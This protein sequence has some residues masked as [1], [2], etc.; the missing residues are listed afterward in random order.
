MTT[1]ENLQTTES[2]GLNAADRRANRK[3]RILG[4]LAGRYRAVPVLVAILT[5]WIFFTSQNPLFLSPRNLTNLSVQ[6]VVTALLALGLVLILVVKEID[7][8]IAALSAV[9]AAVMSKLMVELGLPVVVAI[10]AAILTGM[11]VGLIQGIII[12]RFRAAAFIV[13][14]GTSLAL[15]GVLLYLLPQSGSIALA[16][17][18]IQAIANSFLTPIVGYLLAL[19]GVAATLLLT[20][21]S[22]SHKIKQ[23]MTSRFLT[24]VLLPSAGVLVVTLI[25]VFVLNLD[26]G[27]PTP[28]AILVVLLGVMAYV[29]TQTRFGLYLYAIGGNM[30]A[31]K[32]A[33]ISVDRVKVGAFAIAGALAAIAGIVSASQT[34]GVSAQSG[35]GTLLLEAV[36]A[37]VIGGASLFGGRGSVWAA[38]IGALLMGSIANGLS[39]MSASTELKYVLQGLVLVAAVTVDSLLVW[40]QRRG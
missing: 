26:R 6:I 30:E 36:A 37:A 29:T 8:S 9:S 14:L 12:A 2:D 22:R 17:T 7:L 39:L 32:R 3:G 27:V 20:L 21:Q 33:A 24:T 40:N 38:L 28:V 31:S 5:L 4:A 15:Q 16:G 35:G 25:V 10:I 13:T 23:G 34:L 11:L 1:V 18:P 19:V